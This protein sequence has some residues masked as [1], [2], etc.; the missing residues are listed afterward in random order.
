MG[1]YVILIIIF[2]NINSLWRQKKKK[3]LYISLYFINY[4]ILN[5]CYFV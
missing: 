1:Y 3:N 5:I 2:F 4:K